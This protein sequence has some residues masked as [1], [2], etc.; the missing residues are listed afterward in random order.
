MNT[1]TGRACPARAIRCTTWCAQY[2]NCGSN[3]QLGL[4]SKMS[5]ITIAA[6][7]NMQIAAGTINLVWSKGMAAVSDQF[8]RGSSWGAWRHLL[9]GGSIALLQRPICK[10]QLD[11]STW[12]DLKDVSDHHCWNGQICK[13]RLEQSTWFDRKEWMLSLINCKEAQAKVDGATY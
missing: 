6:T 11:Q 8:R 9:G 4:I 3:N 2:A 13:L 1:E 10:L 12:F 5:L 7:S